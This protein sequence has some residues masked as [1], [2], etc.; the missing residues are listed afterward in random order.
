M[1]YFDYDI[2]AIASVD[3]LFS[4]I[5]VFYGLAILICLFLGI[6]VY[7]LQAYSLYHIAKRRCI[8]KPW[9][10]WLPLGNMWI[11]GSISDQYQYVTQGKIRNKRIGLLVLQ[12]SLIVAALLFFPLLYAALWYINYFLGLAVL[13]LSLTIC[14]LFLSALIVE[15][16]A[17]YRLLASCEP[18]NKALYLLLVVFVPVTLPVLLFICRE[19][20]LGMPPRRPMPE[21]SAEE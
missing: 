21:E 15:Y 3:S 7:V 9:L 4:F 12:T 2:L 14:A 1:P 17:L 5:L 19:K 18:A 13:A 11:L 10:A 6:A 20:D 16:L 8:K